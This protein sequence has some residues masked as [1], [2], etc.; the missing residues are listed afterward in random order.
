MLVDG[1]GVVTVVDWEMVRRGCGA[2][3]VGSFATEAWLLDRFRGKR[4]LLGGFLAGYKRGGKLE[5]AFVR[6][7]VMHMGVHLAY[8]PS[9]VRWGDD[10]ETRGVVG[11]DLGNEMMRWATDEGWRSWLRESL[12]RELLD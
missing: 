1:K 10:A 7:V 9:R 2:T 12:V 8:W 6:R 3:D 5:E 11:L 4:G